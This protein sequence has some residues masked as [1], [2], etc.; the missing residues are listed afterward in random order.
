MSDRVLGLDGFKERW[1]GVTLVEGRFHSAGVFRTI[2]DALAQEPDAS[3]VAIDIP[4]GLGDGNGRRADHEAKAFIGGRGNTVFLTFPEDVL[5]AA[6]HA[7]ANT[8]A[9][10]LTGKGISQQSYALRHKI[11]EAAVAAASDSRLVE[12]HPEVSFRALAGAPL[13]FSKKT[14]NGV[15]ERRDL[16]HAAGIDVP[17]SLLG[18]AGTA[19]PDDV[20]D[21]AIAAW[22]ARRVAQKTAG[23][24]PASMVQTG[25]RPTGVIWY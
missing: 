6:T 15:M 19:P 14:W 11:R 16:L 23:L 3:V 22:T 2:S 1:L 5:S 10:A 8:R 17:N 9:Q 20:L 25:A 13:A 21:A 4:I 18:D 12:V 24:L 7:E